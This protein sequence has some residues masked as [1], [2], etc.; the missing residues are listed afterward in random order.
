MHNW[1]Q[2]QRY[3]LCKA[4]D[5]WSVQLCTV[6]PQ[7]FL[8]GTSSTLPKVLLFLLREDVDLGNPC[9]TVLADSVLFALS[10]FIPTSL[11]NLEGA[12]CKLCNKNRGKGEYAASFTA[13]SQ[14]KN[15]KITFFILRFSCSSLPTSDFAV[16]TVAFG[17]SRI[18]YFQL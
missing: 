18:S 2:L 11:L 6:V 13:S 15:G 4:R 17:L 14:T 10:E 3:F 5:I 12:K 8:I 9:Y 1:M 7:H 16:F